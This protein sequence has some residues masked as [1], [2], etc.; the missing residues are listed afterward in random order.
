MLTADTPER[1]IGEKAYD[2][3]RLAGKLADRRVQLIAPHRANRRSDTVTQDGRAQRRSKRR[4]TVERT[5][6]W[7]QNYRRLC[8]R[9][10]TSTTLF[11]GF[12]PL[13]WAIILLK[14]VYG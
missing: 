12:L 13:G 14:Q 8:I 11:R 10:E 2:S 7:F 6:S 1:V 9:Y 3:D 5:I 4:W